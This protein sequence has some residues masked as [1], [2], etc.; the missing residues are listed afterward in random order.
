M[1]APTSRP[2][3]RRAIKLDYSR[4]LSTVELLLE[5]LRKPGAEATLQHL[6]ESASA[7]GFPSSTS[8]VQ[9]SPSNPV[10]EFGQP[11]QGDT[12]TERYALEPDREANNAREALRKFAQVEAL[13]FV[14]RAW[15][16]D[17]TV[18]VCPVC[19]HPFE[20]GAKRCRR[21]D[22]ESGLQCGASMQ[23]RAV[24]VCVNPKCAADISPPDSPRAGRCPACAAF[25]YRSGRERGVERDPGLAELGPGVQVDGG[26]ISDE[27]V[28]VCE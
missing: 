19:S 1:T 6:Y 2:S 26:S 11:T 21:V 23:T 22:A 8:G 13:V 3:R 20:R 24:A 4:L 14:L 9:S 27:G 16:P 5:E 15:D 17:R 28:F 25:W 10:D 7:E 18:A 12:A